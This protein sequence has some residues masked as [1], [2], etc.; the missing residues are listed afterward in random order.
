[1]NTKTTDTII[2]NLLFV[3]PILHKKLLKI[4]PQDI[5]PSFSLSRLHLGI[6]AILDSTNGPPIS[7][8]AE[9]LLIPRPQM[10][11]LINHLVEAGLAERRQN[12]SDKRVTNIS[13]TQSGKAALKQCEHILK[14]KARQQLSYL[15]E[16]ELEELSQVLAKLRELGV[17]LDNRG[18]HEHK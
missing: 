17:R 5:R 9:K 13:L 10:T 14:N 16:K 7:E 18:N 6:L 1:M 3:L 4:E 15:S 8:I 2:E 11:R 12:S